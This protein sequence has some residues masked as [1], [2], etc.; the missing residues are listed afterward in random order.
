MPELV[1]GLASPQ[2]APPARPAVGRPEGDE[3]TRWTIRAA[4][5][6]MTKGPGTRTARRPATA[7]PQ[8][9]AIMPG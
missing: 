1:T 9:A 7:A 2:Y 4:Q 6:N 8:V 3:I 5:P